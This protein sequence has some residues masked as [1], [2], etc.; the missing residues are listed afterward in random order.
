M[1][2]DA[3]TMYSFQYNKDSILKFRMGIPLVLF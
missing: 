1:L 2:S 3:E